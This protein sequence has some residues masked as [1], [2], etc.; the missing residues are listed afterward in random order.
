[1]VH[2]EPLVSNAADE[3]QIAE[4]NK[5]IKSGTVQ[6]VDDLRKV[7]SSDHGRRVM[8]RILMSGGLFSSVLSNSGS[9]VY[10]N[11]GKQDHALQLK[12]AIEIADENAFAKMLV[13]NS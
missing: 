10:Y 13:E 1:M 12:Q 8:W 11:A 7:L 6:E 3:S 4:A 9:M 2:Q 5:K